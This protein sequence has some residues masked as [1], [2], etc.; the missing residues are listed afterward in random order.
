[1]SMSRVIAHRGARQVA[2]ENTLPA[3]LAAKRLGMKWVE[4]DVLISKDNK[5]NDVDDWFPICS[6]HHTPRP[7]G[8]SLQVHKEL[9]ENIFWK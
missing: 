4:I 7:D 8:G 9:I 5:V 2:P 3:L 1:M 6:A